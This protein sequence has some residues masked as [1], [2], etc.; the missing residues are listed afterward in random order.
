MQNLFCVV[1]SVS[2]PP[3]PDSTH[4]QLSG[5]KD[6]HGNRGVFWWC[7]LCCVAPFNRESCLCAAPAIVLVYRFIKTLYVLLSWLEAV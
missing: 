5:V 2:Y 7:V 1:Y 6:R 3:P 4:T